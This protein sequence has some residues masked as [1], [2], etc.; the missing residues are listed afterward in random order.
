MEAF[1][2]SMIL[3]VSRAW[4]AVTD[5][6][7]GYLVSRSRWTPIGKLMPWCVCETRQSTLFKNLIYFMRSPPALRLSPL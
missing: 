2:V 3:F 7:V 1:Y 5:P 6:L 4:D